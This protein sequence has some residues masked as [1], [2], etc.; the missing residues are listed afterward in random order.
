M[1]TLHFSVGFKPKLTILVLL[2]K[3]TIQNATFEKKIRILFTLK[4]Y[5]QS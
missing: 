4:K 3:N 2:K 1:V 5:I